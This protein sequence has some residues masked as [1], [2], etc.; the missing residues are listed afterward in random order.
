MPVPAVEGVKVLGGA[1][2]GSHGARS[3]WPWR[4]FAPVAVA[5]PATVAVAPLSPRR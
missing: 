4:A 1:R 3:P 5:E 2:R